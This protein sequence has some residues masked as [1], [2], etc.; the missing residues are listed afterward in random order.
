[1]VKP[2]QVVAITS[3]PCSPEYK[4]LANMRSPRLRGDRGFAKTLVSS[5]SSVSP[6]LCGKILSSRWEK[7]C[8]EGGGTDMWAEDVALQRHTMSV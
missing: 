7:T 6:C 1:V 8:I 5:F 4:L 2:A 3:V